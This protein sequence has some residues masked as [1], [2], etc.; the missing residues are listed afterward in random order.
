[1]Y[2]PTHFQEPRL[3]VL[4]ESIREHPLG[5]LVTLGADGLTVEHIPFEI[6][7]EP[8]PFGTLRAHVAMANR[9]R[10]DFSPRL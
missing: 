1:M 2:L 7:P 9:V 3:Q 8:A 6:D 5:A 4:H 10:R